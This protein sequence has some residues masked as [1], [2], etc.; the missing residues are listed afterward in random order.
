M[1]ATLV[2]VLAFA[3]ATAQAGKAQTAPTPSAVSDST[4]PAAAPAPKKKGMFG[5]IK[6]LAKNKVVKTVAKAAL[7]TV[8]PGGQVVASALD[9][10]ESKNVAGA[11]TTAAG[12]TGGGGNCMPGMAAMTGNAATAATGAASVAG[13]G[14]PSMPTTGIGGAAMSAKQMKAMQKQYQQ[15]GMDSAQLAAMQRMMGA[16]PG[17]PAAATVAGAPAAEPASLGPALSREKGR[18]VMRQL[19]W[20]PGSDA[21]RADGVPIF[22][23]A[24]HQVALAMQATSTGYKV[25]ARV[26]EQGGKAQNRLLS[27]KRAAAVVAAL[28]AEGIA[29]QRLRVSDGGADKDVRIV[30]AESK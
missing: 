10:A 22:G 29:P 4:L 7:C 16:M 3:L 5:K 6:G 14:I 17:A 27:Q 15:M 20:M 30:V 18:M 19:P 24:I 23:L 8:V 2:I 26:E 12:L 13:A 25:E 21:L 11:A 9:A 28:T 1:R